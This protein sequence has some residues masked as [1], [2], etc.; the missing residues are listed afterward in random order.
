MLLQSRCVLQIETLKIRWN[1]EL[2][3]EYNKKVFLLT[4]LLCKSFH[5]Y[6]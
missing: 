6:P 3:L 5:F 1:R 4:L 2:N